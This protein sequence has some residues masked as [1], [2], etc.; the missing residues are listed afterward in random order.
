MLYTVF[1]LE[2]I[3]SNMTQSL[4]DSSRNQ[5]QMNSVQDI[6]YRDISLKHGTLRARRD[7]ENYVVEGIVSTDPGD[8]LKEDYFPGSTLK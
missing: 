3:Y 6:E 7:G 8:Y 4:T 5:E 2:R 1:P